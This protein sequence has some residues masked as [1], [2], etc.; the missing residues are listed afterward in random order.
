MRLILQLVLPADARLL[1]RTRRAVAEYLAEIGASAEHVDDVIL[2]LDEACAN[3]IRH[4]FPEGD[5]GT[6]RLVADIADDEVNMSVEDDGVGFKSDLIDLR[7]EADPADCD[8]VGNA[9]A[10]SGRGLE[11]IRRLMTSVEVRSP[12]E[13]GVGTRLQM[14]KRLR[15]PV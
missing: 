11:I 14:H 1:P 10:T 2:A 13:T 8:A 6:F 7:A 4:A 12:T 9:N 3:V 5:D 15:E